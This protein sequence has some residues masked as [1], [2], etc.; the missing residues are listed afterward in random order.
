MNQY[1]IIGIIAGLCTALLNLSGYASGMVGF[2]FILVLISPLPLMI[3]SLGWGTFTGLIAA[4]T[5][6]LVLALWISPLAGF[7]FFLLNSLPAWWFTHLLGRNRVNS[8]TG[9]TAWYPLDR[10]LVWIAAISAI[11]TM[12]MFIPFG[13]SLENYRDTISSLMHQL[14]DAQ[15]LSGP[16]GTA[17]D[18]ESL[19]AIVARL[20]PTASA[21]MLVISSVVNLYLAA[22]IVQKSDRLARPWQDMRTV[23]L[24]PA[25]VYLFMVSLIAL[26]LLDD[27]P[28]IFA[29]IIASSLGSSLM[30]IGLSVL[31]FLTQA[32]QARMALLWTTYFLLF[33][34]QWIGLFLVILGA[35]EVLFNIRS[36][37]PLFPKGPQSGSNQSG[38]GD[39]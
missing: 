10:L 16:N 36:R 37:S 9:E 24:P 25:A 26:F 35:G 12:A 33:I 20:A 4:L 3:A 39:T 13:F 5:S 27:L 30:L 14:Y 31:H 15:Q 17:L 38:S 34:F 32:S 22:K 6:G 11:A 7:L 1:L 23:T 29:Q 28:S 8:E 2:G 21:I 18:L 19:V